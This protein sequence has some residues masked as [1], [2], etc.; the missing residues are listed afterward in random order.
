MGRRDPLGHGDIGSRGVVEDRELEGISRISYARFEIPNKAVIDAGVGIQPH[1]IVEKI[2]SIDPVHR[3]VGRRAEEVAIQSH[4]IA[5]TP[6]REV[7]HVVAL[8]NRE[9]PL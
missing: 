4:F 8:E 9:L 6:I 3:P 7:N 1:G 5:G 2:G